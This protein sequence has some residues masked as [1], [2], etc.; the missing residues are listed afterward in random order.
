MLACRSTTIIFGNLS[1]NYDG[2]SV[3]GT[4][5]TS[6]KIDETKIAC[7]H[8]CCNIGTTHNLATWLAFSPYHKQ[9]VKCTNF[10]C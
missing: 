3:R 9:T 10:F 2:L 8:G 7:E 1:D 4:S 6:N 5:L